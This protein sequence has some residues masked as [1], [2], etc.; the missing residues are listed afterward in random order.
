MER[1]G[2]LGALVGAVAG[3]LVYRTRIDKRT[4]LLTLRPESMPGTFDLSAY[5]RRLVDI[6]NYIRRNIESA[7]R[8][9]RV[10][11]YINLVDHPHIGSR[12]GTP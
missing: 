6:D 2:F 1:R 7:K 10:T 12:W 4:D 11:G 3:V 9:G 8:Q 5:Q